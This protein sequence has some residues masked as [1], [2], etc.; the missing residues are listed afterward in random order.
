M[1][2]KTTSPSASSRAATDAIISSALKSII[3]PGAHLLARPQP[4]DESRVPGEVARAVWDAQHELVEVG[5]EA[6]RI[7]GNPL[8]RHVEVVVAIVETLRI[9]GVRSPRLDHDARD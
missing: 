5:G 1:P 3:D 6:R 4:C 7:A 2:T 9:G 8:P